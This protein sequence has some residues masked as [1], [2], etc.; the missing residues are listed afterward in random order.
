M[1]RTPELPMHIEETY[2]DLLRAAIEAAGTQEE[3][4]ELAGVTQGTI[5]KLLKPASRVTYTTLHKLADVLPELPKPVV[6]VR[7]ADHARWC[8]L[9]AQLAAHRPE[10]FRSL[11]Q[12]T[13]LAV[14]GVSHVPTNEQVDRV[15]AAIASIKPS[16]GLRRNTHK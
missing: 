16:R 4:A 11:L 2:R 15:K 7:D 12:L 8:A 1:G 10:E 9:G 5:S 13:E 6:A 14:A 3:V